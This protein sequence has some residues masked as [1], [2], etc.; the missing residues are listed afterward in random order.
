VLTLTNPQDEDKKVSKTS[1]YKLS[2]LLALIITLPGITVLL[3]LRHY[4]V[5]IVYQVIVSSLVFF[6]CIGLSFKI[7][8]QLVKWG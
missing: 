6:I 8:N 2:T 1:Y 5:D 3:A 7:S 4:D